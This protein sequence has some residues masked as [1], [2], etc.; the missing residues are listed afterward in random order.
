[1]N[2]RF[3]SVILLSVFLLSGV[4]WADGASKD[5]SRDKS[6]AT[7]KESAKKNKI[8]WQ[9]Y[10]DGLKLAKEQ[11]KKVFLEFTAKWC[12]YCKRMRATTFKDLKVVSMLNDNFV[13][14]SVD[15]D[16][17]DSLNIDG[18][19]STEKAVARDYR[20]T[21]YPTFWFL[22]PEG[23]RISSVKGYRD[24]KTLF[25]ILDYMKDDLYKTVKFEDFIKEHKKK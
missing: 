2:I 1:M 17:R 10:D 21:G 8:E 14:V 3:A 20:V 9:K 18:W 25:T 22:T 11:G 7:Q 16:S 15:G 13:V 19:V 23:E 12:G 4:S 6:T 24:T 5:N